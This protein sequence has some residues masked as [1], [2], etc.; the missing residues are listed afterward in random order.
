MCTQLQ[1]T[2]HRL[3][4]LVLILTVFRHHHPDLSVILQSQ[5]IAVKFLEEAGPTAGF[6]CPVL[7]EPLVP[8]LQLH[9]GLAVRVVVRVRHN[10][11]AC[12]R[13][14]DQLQIKGRNCLQAYFISAFLVVI[15]VFS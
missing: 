2:E 12:S 4:K 3:L 14:T 15:L 5:F 13:G 6:L 9:G 8:L 1:R 7:L 11:E 10:Q